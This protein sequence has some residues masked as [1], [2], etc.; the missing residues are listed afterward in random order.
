MSCLSPSVALRD[1]LGSTS[2]SPDRF[3]SRAQRWIRRYRPALVLMGLSILIAELLTGSTP[4]V[5]LLN[6]LGVLFLLGL[7][8]GGVLVIREVT[9][10]WNRGWTP[11]LFLGLA[12][13]IVEEG[14]GTK[15]FFDWAEIGRPDFGPYTHWAGVNWVW[16]GELSLFHAIFSIAL[17]IVLVGLIFP[18]TRGRRFLSDRGVVWTFVAFV[19]TAASMFFLFDRGFVFALPLLAGCLLACLLLVVAARRFPASWFRPRA[20]TPTAS[21]R[22]LFVLGA[23]F[24]WGFFIVFLGLPGLFRD[25]LLTVAVGWTFSAVCFALL[26]RTIGETEHDSHVAYL[27]LGLLSFFVA[28]GVVVEFLG[29]LFVFLAIAVGLFLILHIYRRYRTSSSGVPSAPAVSTT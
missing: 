6:P 21:P 26:R 5:A 19:V 27:A 3:G 29:D 16:A 22:G 14:I 23:G 15:T 25:P 9:A 10:R 24:V 28:F 2:T 20:R 4:V 8:G 11:V 13:G 12:Y 17:P 7:Y 1:P 18:E